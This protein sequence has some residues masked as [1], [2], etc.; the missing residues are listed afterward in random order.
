MSFVEVRADL[1][2][3]AKDYAYDS[4]G[5]GRRPPD[6]LDRNQPDDQPAKDPGN[7]NAEIKAPGCEDLAELEK[8]KHALS[9]LPN[10]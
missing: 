3:E 10:A 1:P 7:R 8:I 5:D 4:D 2:T 6:G 9:L